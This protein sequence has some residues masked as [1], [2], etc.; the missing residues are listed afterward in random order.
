MFAWTSLDGT[1]SFI[2]RAAVAPW[3][4]FLALAECE[5]WIGRNQCARYLVFLDGGETSNEG[6]LVTGR[7]PFCMMY[8]GMCILILYRYI[9]GFFCV[10]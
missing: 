6:I 10:W 7:T 1:F 5:C 9:Y 8:L 4:F 2:F 3:I